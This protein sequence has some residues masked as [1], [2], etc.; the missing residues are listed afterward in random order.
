MELTNSVTSIYKTLPDDISGLNREQLQQV[1]LSTRM[2]E[3]K[4]Q[5]KN[6]IRNSEFN[7]EEF[8][9]KFLNTK[10]KH[11]SRAYGLHIANFI[12]FLSGKSMLDVNFNIVDEYVALVLNTYSKGKASIALASLSSLYSVLV[13]Y[14]KIDRNPWKGA[15]LK[16]EIVS[17][18]KKMLSEKTIECIYKKYNSDSKADRKMR[19]ALHTMFTYGH[20]IG[21]FNSTI[22]YNKET[23]VLSSISKGKLYR[24][25]TSGDNFIEDNYELL[26]EL[27]S[28][29]IQSSFSRTVAKLYKNGIIIQK[30]SVHEYRHHF[31]IVEYK[32]DKDLYR[33]M[34]LLN[35]SSVT[36]TEKYLA[37]MEVL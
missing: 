36:I 18:T 11:T 7:A 9:Y 37:S 12:T 34:R 20:R 3:Y 25:D 1:V 32:K 17:K 21:F 5:I 13:R 6:Q 10:T 33:V 23:G 26:Y 30:P 14:E 16:N 29:S 35:H 27:N 2:D 28:N 24:I 8:I 22:S 31:A 19:V 4:S 15:R